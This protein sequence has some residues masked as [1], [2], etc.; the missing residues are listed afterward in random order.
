MACIL[1]FHVFFSFLLQWAP[2]SDSLWILWIL[3]LSLLCKTPWHHLLYV[4][5]SF[6]NT[7]CIAFL[8]G[9]DMKLKFSF[10]KSPWPFCAYVSKQLCPY[11]VDVGWFFFYFIPYVGKWPTPYNMWKFELHVHTRGQYSQPI[12]SGGRLE[13]P[14]YKLKSHSTMCHYFIK[15]NN[16]QVLCM[17]LVCGK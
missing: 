15:K 2:L 9:L 12:L 5:W 7:K 13:R 1:K 17:N 6:L 10:F 14:K 4:F 11:L 16:P 3:G 8:C